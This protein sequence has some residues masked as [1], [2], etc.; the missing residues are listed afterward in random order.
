[1]S[2]KKPFEYIEEKIK[3]AAENSQPAFDEKAWQ[4]M[5]AKL[6]KGEKKRRPLVWWLVL[7]LLIAAGWGGYKLL[8]PAEKNNIAAVADRNGKKET[9]TNE[10]NN[11][12]IK[13]GDESA[14]ATGKN[15]KSDVAVVNNDQNKTTTLATG[16][17]DANRLNS[18]DNKIA[19]RNNGTKDKLHPPHKIRDGNKG[20]INSKIT[21]A[22][23][24]DV[25]VNQNNNDDSKNNTVITDVNTTNNHPGDIVNNVKDNNPVVND[26]DKLVQQKLADNKTV[27]PKQDGKKVEPAKKEEVKPEKK[28]EEK[29]KK[30]SKGF[31]VQATIGTDAGSTKLFSYNNSSITPKYG[32]GVGY[33]FSN[34]FSI[35]TGFYASNKKYVAGKDDYKAKPDP[36]WDYLTGVKAAC[37]I[38][39]I[40]LTVKVDLLRKPSFNLYGTVGSSYYIMQKEDYDYN[41]FYYDEQHTYAYQYTGNKHFF[42]TLNFSFGI[43]KRLSNKFSLLAEPS[44]GVPLKGVGDGKVKLYS[45]A[46]QV[47]I[48]YWP[49]NK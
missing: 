18:G 17:P 38:Y 35:Q 23:A 36:Y 10:N 13:Q 21:G 40:P 1:M 7:P 20:R 32:I 27:Q 26:D 4:A 14:A 37:L 8:K 5:E 28:K 34:R 22:D 33:Q 19:A 39:E 44:F 29:N 25:A 49:F 42:S 11:T 41:Y 24:G 16:N 2:S 9:G 6:D 12:V 43:E 31:Y 30:V 3:Q 45:S 47:G 46:L 48:K 15:K